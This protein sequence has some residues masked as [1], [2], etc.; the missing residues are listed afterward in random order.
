MAF[1]AGSIRTEAELDL[2]QFRKSMADL[3]SAVGQVNTTL[4]NVKPAKP[5]VDPSAVKKGSKEAQDSLQGLI[6]A[7][8]GIPKVQPSI[9]TKAAEQSLNVLNQ[10]LGGVGKQLGVLQAFGGISSALG[11]GSAVAAIGA[12]TASLVALG[13]EFRGLTRQVSNLTGATGPALAQL[14][15]DLRTL[16]T[17]VP[18]DGG[19]LAQALAKV[20]TELGLI[21]PEARRTVQDIVA[22]SRTF[23]SDV[24]TTTKQAVDVLNAWNVSAADSHKFLGDLT[25]AA[26]LT[27]TDFGELSS[28]L[29]RNAVIFKEFNLTA[30]E[31]AELLDKLGDAGVQPRLVIAAL[32]ESFNQAAKGGADLT[33]FLKDALDVIKAAPEDLEATSTAANAF[34]EALG[35]QLATL[36]RQGRVSVGELQ[37]QV[38][39]AGNVL[40]DSFQRGNTAAANFDKALAS[41]RVAIE[42]L[43]ATA[44]NAANGGLQAL[45]DVMVVLLDS[46]ERLAASPAVQALKD[47]IQFIADH[48][49]T[50]LIASGGGAGLLAAGATLEKNVEQLR[51][52]AQAIRESKDATDAAEKATSGLT[53]GQDASTK[54]ARTL[55]EQQRNVA[56]GA[57]T[58]TKSL[59]EQITAL[60]KLGDVLGI[61]Q[62]LE[63]QTQTKALDEAIQ[64]LTDRTLAAWLAAEKVAAVATGDWE[65][66]DRAVEQ[67]TGHM[68]AQAATQEAANAAQKEAESDLKAIEEGMKKAASAASDQYGA[69]LTELANTLLPGVSNEQAILIKQLLL[70]GQTYQAAQVATAAYGLTLDDFRGGLEGTGQDFDNAKKKAEEFAKAADPSKLLRDDLVSRSKALLDGVI[71][72]FDAATAATLRHQA[73]IEGDAAVVRDK[74]VQM[75]VDAARFD[76]AWQAALTGSTQQAKD[77][78]T[79][80][81]NAAEF[82]QSGKIPQVPAPPK[83]AVDAFAEAMRT[84]QQSLADAAAKTREEIVK[85]E[86]SLAESTASIQATLAQA[87]ADFNRALDDLDA[88]DQEA[89]ATFADADQQRQAAFAQA[90]DDLAREAD[91]ALADFGT[92]IADADDAL[93]KSID[94]TSTSALESIERLNKKAAESTEQAV[95]AQRQ[96]LTALSQSLTAIRQQEAEANLAFSRSMQDLTEQ[97]L[98]T[99]QT[100][101]TANE[102][103]KA[104]LR[105]QQDFGLQEAALTTQEAQ[106]RGT[107]GRAVTEADRQAIKQARAIAE[108]M[109]KVFAEQ[110]KKRREAQEKGDKAIAQAEKQ[111]DAKLATIERKM[112]DLKEKLRQEQEKARKAEEK[113]QKQVEKQRTELQRKLDQAREKAEQD[114]DKAERKFAQRLEDIRRDQIKADQEFRKAQLK[115]NEDLARS[116]KALESLGIDHNAL[117]REAVKRLGID[118]PFQFNN[119]TIQETAV[120]FARALGEKLESRLRQL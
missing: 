81:A 42:P 47:L 5:E 111:L 96:A 25:R 113:R 102:L 52:Q 43:G 63:A 6:S 64:N 108:E 14:N 16:M 112:A 92:S 62:L 117:L 9:D 93:A 80:A 1:D 24:P 46:V 120:D 55:E 104:R 99:Q 48:K 107:F 110:E 59:E 65:R 10:A 18:A 39:A 60:G 109:R 31:G 97:S 75:G 105:L 13:Q 30:V 41:L 38:D 72:S 78:V 85:A 4:G 26:Q 71:G 100:H 88:Q 21:G 103:A 87:Q 68:A 17:T 66:W 44:L 115:A 53:A 15:Q 119:T 83:D 73:A 2:A 45:A 116:M 58:V 106:A 86:E 94:E 34:S 23:G 91:T 12:V 57:K 61:Q 33:T 70:T 50:F 89:R 118:M 54:S 84:A 74:L 8:L 76:A 22:M 51:A 36:I 101:Q 69:R 98:S 32:R 27:G 95:E 77:F 29:V 79:A 90:M 19:A 37:A 20:H 3:Q 11:A 35:P 82:L 56:L 40:E 114:Q 28:E 49:E 67:A 7:L